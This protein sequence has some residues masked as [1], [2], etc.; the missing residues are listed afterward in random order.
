MSDWTLTRELQPEVAEKISE[1]LSLGFMGGST[2]GFIFKN[3]DTGLQVVV[4]S[5]SKEGAWRKLYQG[6]YTVLDED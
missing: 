6:E 1:I 5:T 3:D 2:H 4:M